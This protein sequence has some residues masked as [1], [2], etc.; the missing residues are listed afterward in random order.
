MDLRE[1]I[2]SLLNGNSEK[3]YSGMKILR[4]VP[5]DCFIDAVNKD[6]KNSGSSSVLSEEDLEDTVSFI[7]SDQVVGEIKLLI[8]EWCVE[9]GFTPDRS[10]KMSRVL[11]AGMYR[12]M[13][14]GLVVS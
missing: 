13:L 8:E 5:D 10:E 2:F 1:E 12:K 3:D 11:I 14:E 9:N 6:L 4:D 7:E